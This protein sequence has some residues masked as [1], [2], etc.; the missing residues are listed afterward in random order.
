[1]QDI[2]GTI[3]NLGLYIGTVIIG[4][5]IY[6]LII[7]PAIYAI[8]LRRNPIRLMSCVGKAIMTALGTASR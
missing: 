5:I 4:S 1:M 6:G 3:E 8:L 7:L 2:Q